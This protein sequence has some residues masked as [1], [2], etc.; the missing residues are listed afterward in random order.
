MCYS[1]VADHFQYLASLGPIALGTA[2]AS[3]AATRALRREPD[4]R[5]RDP[6]WA[7]GNR[8]RRPR[9]PH[10][11]PYTL[12]YRDLRTL[13]EDTL[14]KTP[15]LDGAQQPRAARVAGGR[16]DAAME[17]YRAAIAVKPARLRA[18]QPAARSPPKGAV[19][20]T[21]SPSSAR[22]CATTRAMP[23]HGA[24]RQRAR[25]RG[26]LRRG[27]RGLSS[28]RRGQAGGYADA[29]SNLG[30]VLFLTGGPTRRFSSTSSGRRARSR[31]RRRA[32]QPGRRAR[33]ARAGSARR[34]AS[35]SRRAA[36]DRQPARAISAT[37]SRARGDTRK[38]RSAKGGAARLQPA[39]RTPAVP[40]AAPA[41]ARRRARRDR[42]R[43]VH[44]RPP[45]CRRAGR[46]RDS[47]S[48]TER[49][50]VSDRP[51]ER[52]EGR[53]T[54]GRRR[55][56]GVADEG[57]DA[58][59]H[60]ARPRPSGTPCLRRARISAMPTARSARSRN[61][62]TSRRA[63]SRGRRVHELSTFDQHEE[64]AAARA[65]IWA[66]I[67]SCTRANGWRSIIG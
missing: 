30:N 9:A 54:P 45:A 21:R 50:G 56:G 49:A 14:A 67:S 11:P 23:R 10:V 28:C 22:R 1:F 19:A 57:P 38:P 7:R 55:G 48:A 42:A 25:G 39:G 66:I 31:V 27:D 12:I 32:L 63:A 65:R 35:S 51:A 3:W 61:A 15:R 4:T 36:C 20:P 53:P 24:L 18:Q 17:H 40:L 47:R 60:R 52:A 8:A 59:P 29:R 13:W 26:A 46:D 44:C 58:A 34:R 62:A 5:A 2:L 16:L 43:G 6:R 41:A 33:L 37:C 64:A